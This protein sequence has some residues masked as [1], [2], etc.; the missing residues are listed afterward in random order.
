MHR[1]TSV[2]AVLN[3]GGKNIYLHIH[4]YI[5]M[6]MMYARVYIQNGDIYIYV[7]AFARMLVRAVFKPLYLI[8]HS[9]DQYR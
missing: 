1:D 7:Y 2:P 3:R 6:C 5:H 9:L 8:N 4:I